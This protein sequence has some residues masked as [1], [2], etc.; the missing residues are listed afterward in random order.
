MVEVQQQAFATVEKSEPEDVVPQ[1]RELRNDEDI[2]DES[3]PGAAHLTRGN[4]Q[5]AA[6]RAVPVHVLDVGFQRRVGVVDQVVIERGAHA[7]EGDGLV[8]GAI[9][10]LRRRGE[11]GGGAAEEAQFRIGIKAAVLDP[12]AEEEIAAAEVV[13]VGGRVRGQQVLDLSLE[14]GAEFLIGVEREDPGSGALGDGGVLGY[15][16]ALPGFVEHLGVERAGDFDG[17]VG[18][19]GVENDD[20]V[21]KLDAGQ[22][23]REIRLL[24]LGDDGDG[25]S[26]R[27]RQ[28][29]QGP[30]PFARSWH[31]ASEV[32]AK[33]SGQKDY[34]IFGPER[35]RIFG[36]YKLRRGFA[37][38]SHKLFEIWLGSLG[39]SRAT[40]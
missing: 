39:Q 20:L 16:E 30:F 27:R 7:V 38:I 33:Y 37:A 35:C 21:G 24:I 11:V 1:E 29:S 12:A 8:D 25:E 32:R 28:S 40:N 10:E 13:G 5:G 3:R 31:N 17:A 26:L 15:G 14:L 2:A 9:L 6:E 36:A 4:Q 23:A 22:S 19:G 18:G 34:R